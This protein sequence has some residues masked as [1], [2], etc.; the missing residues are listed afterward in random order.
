MRATARRRARLVP[1]AATLGLVAGFG[2]AA[3]QGPTE[4]PPTG[5]GAGAQGGMPP[6]VETTVAF[7]SW[8][9]GAG[10]LHIEQWRCMCADGGDACVLHVQ[11]V[12]P[13]AG[14][15]RG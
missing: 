2:L 15:C 10:T 9:N 14:G 3:C 8:C 7:R 13:D 11:D 12:H 1:A 4:L 5:P 6:A